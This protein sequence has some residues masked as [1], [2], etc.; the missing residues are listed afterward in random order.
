MS[1][2]NEKLKILLFYSTSKY[3]SVATKLILNN[4]LISNSFVE[5]F[6]LKEIDFDKNNKL[7]K[8][9]NVTG[10]PTTLV[11]FKDQL[12]ARHLG[13]FTHKELNILLREVLQFKKVREGNK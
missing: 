4:Y 9:Y 10:V 1:N 13:E 7:C 11:F 8:K 12:R 5:E 2:D 6:T 3:E